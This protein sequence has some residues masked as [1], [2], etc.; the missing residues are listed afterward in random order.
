VAGR[1]D[2]SLQVFPWH[3]IPVPGAS[4]QDWGVP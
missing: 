3:H 4:E 2:P 1:H